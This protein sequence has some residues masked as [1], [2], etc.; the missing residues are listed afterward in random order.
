MK[1]PYESLGKSM[2]EKTWGTSLKTWVEEI[3]KSLAINFG[4]W[5]QD[6]GASTLVTTFKMKANRKTMKE[7]Q[8]QSICEAR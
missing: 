3:Q 8:P 7:S 4:V 1:S 5:N 2:N 6:I